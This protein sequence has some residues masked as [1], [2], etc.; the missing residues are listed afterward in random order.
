MF[1][2]GTEKVDLGTRNDDYSHFGLFITCPNDHRV[3][4]ANK[5]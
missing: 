4:K 5:I 1:A 3:Q 2:P